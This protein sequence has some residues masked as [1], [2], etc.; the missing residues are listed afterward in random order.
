MKNGVGMKMKKIISIIIGSIITMVIL[1]IVF[2]FLYQDPFYILRPAVKIEKIKCSSDKDNDGI[3]DVDEIISGAR[4]EV[5]NKTK[6]AN[7]YYIGGYPPDDEGVCTDVIWRAYKNAGYDIKSLVDND[8][9]NKTKDYAVNTPDPNIDFRRV[10]NL[11]IFFKKYSDNLTTDV[12]PYDIQNLKE[13][14]P[15][16]IVV[17]NEHIA[18]VSDKRRKD[19]VPFI[20]H[21]ASFHAKEEDVLMWWSKNGRIKGH[22]RFP[23]NKE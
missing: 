10:K 2:Y 4:R 5:V 17:L 6:Y 8:I 12:K 20:I 1:G 23:K 3:N 9:K 18:I 16:D 19:G 21:N 7:R 13:W 11:Y 15:G 22:F 14:Q